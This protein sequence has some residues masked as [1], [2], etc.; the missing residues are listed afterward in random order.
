MM[1]LSVKYIVRK[2][3]CYSVSTNIISDSL[4]AGSYA[5]V[6]YR[7][8]PFILIFLRIIFE[9]ICL[10]YTSKTCRMYCL[11]LEMRLMSNCHSTQSLQFLQSF[12]FR[13]LLQKRNQTN[14]AE[15]FEI[16][17]K[18]FKTQDKNIFKFVKTHLQ[19]NF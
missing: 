19:W 16:P 7:K 18:S 5:Q 13:K 1:A 8:Y 15:F 9:K 3:R 6:Q 17:N 14:Y 2:T 12:S 10:I 11:N 4:F